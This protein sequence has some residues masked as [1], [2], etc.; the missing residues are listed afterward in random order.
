MS[1]LHSQVCN[2]AAS[3]MPREQVRAQATIC[4]LL[5]SLVVGGAEVLAARL[6]RQFRSDYRFV[7]VCLDELGT[8]GHELSDDG[9]PVYVLHRRGGVDWHCMRRLARILRHESV[10]LLHAHQYTPFFY[11]A[12]SRMLAKNV[13]IVFTEHGRH[14]PDHPRKKRMIAN[15]ILL[16]RGDR[17]FGVGHAVRQALVDNDGFA[18]ERVRVI[19]NGID[20][21]PYDA[22]R[23][24]RRA[25]VRR[26][27][28][29][30]PHELLIVQ[31]A[32][33]DYLKDHATA[34]R[35][36]ARICQRRPEARLLL[37]G[38]G[39]E[40]PKIEREIA[41]RHLG[42]SVRL[43]GLRQDVPALLAAADLFWLTSISEG[44]PLTIIEAMAAGVPV[45]ATNVGGIG[46]VIDADRTG[47]LVGSGDDAALANSVCRLLESE[48]LRG[49]LT[50]TARGD[51]LNRFSEARMHA[52]YAAVYEEMLNG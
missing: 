17:L 32:R 18:A 41:E 20:L 11:A 45:V 29:Y 40:R 44:I 9:F 52:S 1:Q 19:H 48:R 35:A 46:E 4:Q 16:R 33:L 47:L 8:L 22:P 28:G 25:S 37:V 13:P 50:E 6:A 7:F 12:A 26:E 2:R 15:R 5:H 24:A 38:E 43:L 39:P 27:L 31:V 14:Y 3:T 30:E 51:A 34:I 10:R 49:R 42:H 21:Q 23:D 36:F